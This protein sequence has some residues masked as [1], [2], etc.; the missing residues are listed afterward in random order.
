MENNRKLYIFL[1]SYFGVSNYD[2]IKH[3][4]F[5]NA[6]SV[7]NSEFERIVFLEFL[8]KSK[9]SFI[10]A[11]AVGYWPKKCRK[12]TV[13]KK[14]LIPENNV[15]F[16]SYKTIFGLSHFS[17]KRSMWKEIKKQL[18]KLDKNDY[19]NVVVIACEAH[20]P[21]LEVLSK[22][23][24]KFG[25]KTA[26]IVPDL[27]ENMYSSNRWFY[28]FLK[29]KNA[30]RMYSL[31]NKN[32]DS[33]WF[34]TKDISLK[35]NTFGKQY[36]V[37]EG[38]IES[39]QSVATHNKKTVCTYIGKTDYWNGIDFIIEAAKRMSNMDFNIFGSGALD[40]YLSNIGIEN[41]HFHHFLDPKNVEKIIL[42]SDVLL[43]PR[44]SNAPFA[45]T[46]F[47]SKVLK[48]CSACKPIVTFKL[49]CYDDKYNDLLFYPTRNNVDSFCES[50]VLASNSNNINW[51][52]KYE[53]KLSCLLVNNVVDNFIKIL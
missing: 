17:K 47:P 43:S 29:N 42:S 4:Y 27:P 20:K 23:K 14:H 16:C 50:I 8:K 7:S 49:G 5:K 6:I 48:Y 31:A 40:V 13:N 39:F 36:I 41:L 51:K 33:F 15:S 2:I 25:I 1:G 53:S 52:E 19:K 26:L 34:F 9:C 24:K 32:V 38:V 37:R 28:K 30:K 11:P 18:S 21:Y 45:S 12:I 22:S 10:S 44:F 46:A 35:F 3:R